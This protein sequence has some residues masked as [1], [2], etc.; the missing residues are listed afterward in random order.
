MTDLY[1]TRDEEGQFETHETEAAARCNAEEILD[2]CHE[3]SS[4]SGWPA[5]TGNIEWGRLIP[6][7]ECVAS[8]ERESDNPEF[9]YLIDYNLQDLAD[10]TAA[11][12]GELEAAQKWIARL[13]SGIREICRDM[14]HD[15]RL[16]D[17]VE[18]LLTEKPADGKG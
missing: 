2:M 6:L 10:P 15:S 4:S 13:T 18:S 5:G 12:Q 1:Y 3:D 7:G 16:V 9:D 11:P 8:N 17:R 14:P